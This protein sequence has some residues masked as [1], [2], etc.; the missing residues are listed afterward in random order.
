NNNQTIYTVQMDGKEWREHE[1]WNFHRRMTFYYTVDYYVR[2]LEADTQ[3]FDGVKIKGR[4]QGLGIQPLVDYAEKV[5]TPAGVI[6]EYPIWLKGYLQRNV[7]AFD[8]LE[9]KKVAVIFTADGRVVE[10]EVTTLFK[11]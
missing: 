6:K 2:S 11:L 5:Y 4:L 8:T 3:A 10:Q 1:Y 7:G 9:V